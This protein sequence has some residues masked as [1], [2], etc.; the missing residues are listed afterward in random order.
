M[1]LTNF[2]KLKVHMLVEHK[3]WNGRRKQKVQKIQIRTLQTW[4]S[5]LFRNW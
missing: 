2:E 4:S 5:N 1:D 3:L